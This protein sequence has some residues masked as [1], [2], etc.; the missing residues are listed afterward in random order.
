MIPIKLC[1]E[2]GRTQFKILHDSLNFYRENHGHESVKRF[3][4]RCKADYKDQCN[5]LSEWLENKD[6]PHYK[7]HED[8]VEGF[9]IFNEMSDVCS[10][11][12]FFGGVLN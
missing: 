4:D 11:L 9:R 8:D 12:K 6:N 7:M 1:T 2:Y 3:R 5:F 10:C